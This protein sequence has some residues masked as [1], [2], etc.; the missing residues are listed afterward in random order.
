M[1]LPSEDD[2]K[3]IGN[4]LKFSALAFQMGI[5]I[6]IAAYGGQWFDHRQGNEKPVWTIVLILLAIFASLYQIIREVIKMTKEDD[7]R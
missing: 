4:Y 1:R 2:K 5:L 6:V 3:K 7:K